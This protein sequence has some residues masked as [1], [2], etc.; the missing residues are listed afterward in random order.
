MVD[1]VILPAVAEDAPALA[2]LHAESWRSAYRGMLPDDYLDGPILDERLQFWGRRM[3]DLDPA[4]TQVL[5]AVSEPGLVGFVCIVL[6]ADAIWG[7]RLENLHVKPNLKGQGI[8]GRLFDAAVAWAQAARPARPIHLWVLEQNLP[9][10]RFYEHR[11]GRVADTK[12]IEV[13]PGVAV[14]EVRYIW[15]G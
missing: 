14:A 11:G 10:R 5:K 7:A 6:E 8:G 15:D 1:T 3:A 4:C 12:T 2:S 13:V 9:A